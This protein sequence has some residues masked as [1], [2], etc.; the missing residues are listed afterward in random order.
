M[1]PYLLGSITAIDASGRI[2]LLANIMI[3][4]GLAIGPAVAANLLGSTGYRPV[5]WMGLGF[6]SLCFF[7]FL[8]LTT[9]PDSPAESLAIS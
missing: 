6:M 4:G 9:R 7:L 8:P 3:G 5:V 1:L 2:I